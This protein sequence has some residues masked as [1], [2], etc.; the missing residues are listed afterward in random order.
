MATPNYKGAP[1]PANSGWLSGLGSLFSGQAPAY[2]GQVQMTQSAGFFGSAAP[3]YKTAPTAAASATTA[4]AAGG[5]D[6]PERITV[7]IPR[8]LIDPDTQT[9]Q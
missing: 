9:E 6:E 4:D 3:A 7:L 5:C 8:E 1:V 2:A